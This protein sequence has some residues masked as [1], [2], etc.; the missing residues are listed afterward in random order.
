MTS[1]VTPSP[2]LLPAI[3]QFSNP[4]LDSLTSSIGINRN[5]LA[6]EV[7]IS[8]AWNNLPQLLTEI[9]PDKRDEGIMRMCVA[10]ASGLFDAAINY[11]WNASIV[12]LRRKIRIF[13]INIVPQIIGRDFDESKLLDL[14]DS[15][16]LSLCLKLNLISE[17]GYFMLSQCRD[18]RNNFSV[19]HPAVGTLDEYEF[20]NFLNRCVRHALCEEYNAEAV[21]IKYLMV[22]LN[23]TGFS[24]E[25]YQIWNEKIGRT[26]DAQREAIFGMLH[27]LYCDPSKEEHA[28]VNAINLCKEFAEEFSPPT[29]STLINQHQRYQASGD[30]DRYVASQSFFQIIGKL[31]LLSETE[32]H[33]MISAACRRLN[34]VHGGMN[35]FYNEPPFADRLAS[36]SVGHQIPDT[37]RVEFV[38]TVVTCSV[39]NPYGTSH[40]ADIY[41]R[42]MIAGMSPM[43]IGILL[44][45]PDTDTLVA[46]R[47]RNFDRCRAKFSGIV[48]LL[49]GSSIP[50]RYR[51]VY[52][53]WVA[54]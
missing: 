24:S 28:R 29:I 39:G 51:T 12:E 32:R 14:Q 49:D 48:K 46:K 44:S 11:A 1:H 36:L 43:E 33:A 6:S 35:N 40:A 42:N 8:T 41:Y 20:I 21:D 25:Q 27:G 2:V 52:E 3:H 18:I 5:V 4:M 54:S 37:A 9:P 34:N 47:I 30:N 15:E 23:A 7:Q 50:T 17:A 31:A 38:E 19:A 22:A 53:H 16:L 13:G 10:V 26:F 45:L